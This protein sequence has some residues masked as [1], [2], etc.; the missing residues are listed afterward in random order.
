MNIAMKQGEM[1]LQNFTETLLITL[2]PFS[3]KEISAVKARW[4]VSPS[5][6]I[7]VPSKILQK[8]LAV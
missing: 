7:T 1:D 6:S 2:E 8:F 4:R 3:S 5:Q